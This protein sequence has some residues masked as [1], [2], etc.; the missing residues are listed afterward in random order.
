MN[1]RKVCTIIFSVGVEMRYTFP[2]ISCLV[3]RVVPMSRSW[4]KEAEI[5]LGTSFMSSEIRTSL[6]GHSVF[7][8]DRAPRMVLTSCLSVLLIREDS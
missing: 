2:D 6:E 4:Y 5:G 1:F 3:C 8:S 7:F